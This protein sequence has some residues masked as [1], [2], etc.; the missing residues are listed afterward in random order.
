[1]KID[2]LEKAFIDSLHKNYEKYNLYY[3]YEYKIFH[4]FKPLVS[5]IV[6][7]LIL[8]LYEA[9]ITLTNHFLES[10]LKTALINNDLGINP[11]PTEEWDEKF[12]ASSKMYNNNILAKNIDLCLSA[13]LLTEDEANSHR[14]IKNLMRN[15][16]SHA[17][18]SQ[19]LKG[20]SF[21]GVFGK[22]SEPT[23]LTHVEFD[24]RHC[25]PLQRLA[26][27]GFAREN[28]EL[29]FQLIFD[30]L[31]KMELRLSAK[32]IMDKTRDY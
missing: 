11:I 26:I 14:K 20:S 21:R 4:S 16:F 13:K 7:C 6:K 18:P 23:K 27:S 2:T 24:L 5:E 28:A 17:D 22:F 15:G 12:S 25:L 30:L 1:M 29:Y 19:I 9:A 32:E 8:E 10:L 3:D 31:Y